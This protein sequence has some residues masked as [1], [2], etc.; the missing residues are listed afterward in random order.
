MLT[1]FTR[2]GRIIDKMRVGG[3]SDFTDTFRVFVLQPSL[4]FEI[5]NYHNVYKYDPDQAGYEKNYVLHSELLST[6]NYRIAPD[7][8]FEK[9]E[10]PLAMR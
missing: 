5:R 10:T 9:V 6:N 3:Q 8:R 4:A 2:N 7:G 1:S